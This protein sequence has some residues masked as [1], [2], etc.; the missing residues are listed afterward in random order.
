MYNDDF[1]KMLDDVEQYL[2]IDKKFVEN[3]DRMQD[4]MTACKLACEL[5][6]D[7]E[8]SILQDPLQLG[9]LIL[10]IVDYQLDVSATRRIKTFNEIV[11][12]SDNFAFFPSEDEKVELTIMFNGVY[13]V[14]AQ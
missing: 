3:S 6:H 7:A 14:V 9:A 12:K 1:K 2:A 4:V 13:S 8:I 11:S 5:F 10:Q